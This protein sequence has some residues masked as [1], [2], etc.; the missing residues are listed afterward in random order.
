MNFYNIVSFFY[1]SYFSWIRICEV[2]LCIRGVSHKY[3]IKYL[4]KIKIINSDTSWIRIREYPWS[5]GI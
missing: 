5:I 2:S 4:L 1:S 3:P